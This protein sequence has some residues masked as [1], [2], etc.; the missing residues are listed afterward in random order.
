MPPHPQKRSNDEEGSRDVD[1]EES[2]PVEGAADTPEEDGDVAEDE[3]TEGE[4]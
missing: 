4:D 3:P 2:E 1:C